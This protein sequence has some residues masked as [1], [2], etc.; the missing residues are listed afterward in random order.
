[1]EVFPSSTGV[2]GVQLPAEKIVRALSRLVGKLGTSA[3]DVRAF[4]EAI[5]TT[6]TRPKIA[7]AQL[8]TARKGRRNG[9]AEGGGTIHSTLACGPLAK[10]AGED[11]TASRADSRSHRTLGA[12]EDRMGRRRSKLGPHSCRDW[13]I[14]HGGGSRQGGHFF[15]KSAGL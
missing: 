12:G 9:V 5:M 15:W 8:G 2:I 3:V 14:G 10:R 11:G 6:D 1:D 13:R 7:A 4:A